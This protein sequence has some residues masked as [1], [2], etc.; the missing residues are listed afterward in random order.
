MAGGLGLRARGGGPSQG[1]PV[2]FALVVLVECKGAGPQAQMLL[3]EVS[4]IASTL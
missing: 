4:N 3:M 2:D 1:S